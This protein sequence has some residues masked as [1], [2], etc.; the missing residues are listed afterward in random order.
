MQHLTILWAL[1]FYLIKINRLRYFF[2]YYPRELLC[3]LYA[4]F[5][6]IPQGNQYVFQIFIEP[7]LDY[8]LVILFA[9]FLI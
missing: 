6:I 1:V 8:K 3:E 2:R 4:S 7:S 5:S 9:L